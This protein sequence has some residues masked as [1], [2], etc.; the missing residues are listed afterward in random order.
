MR[1]FSW[2]SAISANPRQQKDPAARHAPFLPPTTR[3]LWCRALIM[4]SLGDR[5]AASRQC[6]LT[7]LQELQVRSTDETA[8][9][10]LGRVDGGRRKWPDVA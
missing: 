1:L 4:A 3:E 7:L 9:R 2:I 6:E 10:R 8:R 5:D